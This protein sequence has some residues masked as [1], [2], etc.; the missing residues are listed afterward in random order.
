MKASTAPRPCPPPRGRPGYLSLQGRHC[1]YPVRSLD[2][3]KD[4]ERGLSG[5]F[6]LKERNSSYDA[7]CPAR[8][9][10]L[11]VE[12]GKSL[13]CAEAQE[14]TGPVPPQ[15]W[16]LGRGA[17]LTLGPA[18]PLPSQRGKGCAQVPRIPDFWSV[19]WEALLP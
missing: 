3:T 17:Q 6:L 8:F 12:K 16:C 14:G 15:Q 2:Y 11:P 10:K 19:L 7:F 18:A 5:P 1:S 9:H 13:L 4:R